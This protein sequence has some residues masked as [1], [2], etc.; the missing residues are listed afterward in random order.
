MNIK[1]IMAIGAV[2]LSATV[3]GEVSS[4]NIVGYTTSSLDAE[5]WYLIG[6]N[7][8]KT[9][10]GNLSIQELISGLEPGSDPSVAP[11]IQY[12]NGTELVTLSYLDFVWSD[13]AGDFVVA[14]ATADLEAVNLEAQPGFGCW[15]KL[16]T[17][18]TITCAGQVVET[19]SASREVTSNWGLMSSPYPMAL[20]LNSTYF[21]CSGLVASSEASEAPTIQ[22]WDGDE[23]VSLTYCDFVW[24]DDAAD[25]VVAWM[26][27]NMEYCN[28]SLPP[29][30]GFWIKS[31]TGGYVNFVR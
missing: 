21:D 17:A 12:W 30:T 13:D 28:L 15:L 2:A 4:A 10:S 5:K 26:D 27:S 19:A 18:A 8:E 6:S 7:F 31:A 1:S 14:W 24:S 3:F 20:K 29:C 25:F 16:P 11:T 23:L 22:Y 9:G